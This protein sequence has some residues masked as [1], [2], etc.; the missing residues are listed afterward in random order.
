MALR[1]SPTKGKELSK[2]RV[3][4]AFI[5]SSCDYQ[6]FSRPVNVNLTAFVVL[7]NIRSIPGCS[8]SLF[9]VSIPFSNSSPWG[10]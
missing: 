7:A 1:I 3:A 9:L 2:T 8:Y 5:D 6:Q 10:F 4:K